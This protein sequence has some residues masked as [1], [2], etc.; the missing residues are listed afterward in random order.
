MKEFLRSYKVFLFLLLLI[1]Y[2]Y[3]GQAQQQT[4]DF[5]IQIL[6]KDS[7]NSVNQWGV[8]V[9]P[10]TGFADG[11]NGT[12]TASGQVTIL[13]NFSASDSITN[14]ESV[15][16]NWNPDYDLVRVPSVGG[17]CSG[18]TYS[19]G[20]P[21][22]K[23]YFFI[24]LDDE[25]AGV[26]L[27]DGIETLLF[28]FQTN[29]GCPDSLSLINNNTDPLNIPILNGDCNSLG[30]NPGMDL[31]VFNTNTGAIHNWQSNYA[32]QA[33]SC[34]DCDGDGIPD[35]LE[36][37]NGNEMFDVGVDS[38]DFCDPCDP[39]G[40]KNFSAMLDGGD[41]LS[42][43]SA[44]DSAGLTTTM[45]GG[46][47]PFTVYLGVTPN[48]GTKTAQSFPNINSG[49][50]FYV[51]PTITTDYQLDSIVD[52]LGCTL[53]DPDSLL[54]VVTVVVEG[55]IDWV[56]TGDTPEDVT[57]CT[58]DTIFF[59]VQADNSGDGDILYQWQEST[60]GGTT[61]TDIVNGTPYSLADTDSLLISNPDG[62]DGNLYRAKIFTETCDT[63]T[64]NAALLSVEGPFEI[65]ASPTDAAICGEDMVDFVAE[66]ANLGS[67]TIVRQWEVN[68]GSGWT[69]LADGGNYSGVTTDVLSIA[70]TAPGD[71]VSALNEHWYR[72]R[73]AGTNG[74]CTDIFTDSAQLIVEGP[75]TIDPLNLPKDTSSCA[76][77]VACFGVL[78][79]NPGAGDIDYQ[80]YMRQDAASSWVA[81]SNDGNF[82]GVRSDTLCVADAAGL[83]G[84]QFEVRFS[85]DECIEIAT[86]S[87]G[88][89]A[90]LS[91]TETIDFNID[92][93]SESICGSDVVQFIVD[94]NSLDPMLTKQ[95]QVSSDTGQTWADVAASA[96]YSG[97][98][99]DTLTVTTD[100]TATTQPDTLD[101]L[102]YRMS[103]GGQ[104]CDNVISREAELSVHVIDEANI[105]DPRDTTVCSGEAAYFEINVPYNRDEQE[106]RYRW[107]IL[108]P[109]GSVWTNLNPVGDYNGV[110]TNR[111]SISDV[112]G[113]NGMQFRA[114]VF[115]NECDTIFTNLATLT[116]EGPYVFGAN[117]DGHPQDTVVCA[118]EAVTFNA[119]PV[120]DMSTLDPFGVVNPGEN[121][122]L[123][124]V[125]VYNPLGEYNNP[126]SVSAAPWAA[127]AGISGAFTTT[128]DIAQVSGTGHNLDGYAF[129]LEVRSAEC[130][131]PA[132]SLP[133]I[134][135]IDG[136]LSVVLQPLDAAN[137]SDQGAV[138]AADI[139]NAGFGG[140]QTIEY[141]WREKDATTGVWRDIENDSIYNGA[142]SDTLSIDELF[143][144]NDNEYA[145][146]ATID[147]CSFIST[148]TVSLTEEG[149]I[150][151][152]ENPEDVITCSGQPGYFTATVI[153]STT[154]DDSRLTYN[155]QVSSDF[156][157]NWGNLTEGST[158]ADGGVYTLVETDSMYISDVT[159]L[160]GFRYRLAIT[161]LSGSCDT[162]FSTPARITAEGPIVFDPLS[163]ESIC[164]NEG[165]T[166]AA[167]IDLD[168]TKAGIP[169]L[170]WQV[171]DGSGWTNLTNDGNYDAVTTNQ[172]FIDRIMEINRTGVHTYDTLLNLDGYRYRIASTTKECR[173]VGTFFFSDSL[174]LN[175]VS[176]TTGT[177]DFDL[178]G[179][180]ND[181]DEDDDNDGLRDVIE[182][183]ITDG[184]EVVDSVNQFNSDT[185]FDGINDSEED[186]D[187]DTIN[188][189]EETDDDDGDG[190]PDE[191]E[192]D[193]DIFSGD[194]LDPCDPIL[195]PTCVGVVLD[196]KVKLQGAMVGQPRV[197]SQPMRDDLRE[198]DMIPLQEPYGSMK[199]KVLGTEQE[200]AFIH[201]PDHIGGDFVAGEEEIQSADKTAILGDQPNTDNNVIDW[202]FVELRSGIQLDSIIATRSALLQADG[203]VRDVVARQTPDATNKFLDSDGYT[204]LRFDSTLAGEYYVSV[205]H[206]NHL[207]VMTNEA[208]L[209]SPKL[210]IIDFIDKDMNALGTHPMNVF[211]TS[212]SRDD[213]GTITYADTLEQHMW[214]GDL[215]S[216]GKA[217]F[218][219][220]QN[221]VNEMFINVINLQPVVQGELPLDNFILSGYRRSD[222]NLD[223]NT[224]YQGPNND[225]Q[226]LIFNSILAFPDNQKL[227]ANYVI[228]E[229]LP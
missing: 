161:N 144:L 97:V 26:P 217:I 182:E 107:Q 45:S 66:T 31:A 181:V 83:D 6:E 204:Y 208:G 104:F 216:D 46:E 172:L 23:D 202:V 190:I 193:G 212:A 175:T 103:V 87:L 214:A 36:D 132:R 19:G 89:P 21:S 171:D 130:A 39:L 72:L 119:D 38:S 149:P 127:D 62:L 69:N 199:V 158:S 74:I 84:F 60:D 75:I 8:Y 106:L 82:S 54:G 53:T 51:K 203:D 68:D 164:S 49:D 177:C 24:G 198:K 173:A 156:G 20:S 191:S 81:I 93:L 151:V 162:V 96:I 34:E 58:L 138:F 10:S 170:Q 126:D 213:K 1:L 86:S 63:L 209:L 143:G 37:T 116:V 100:A 35:G 27:E 40:I 14:I 41:I 145:L 91:V 133:A 102:L 155:W 225:R 114:A 76:G 124:Y 184:G 201:V 140:E 25:G 42:V 94:I 229:Q 73:I 22:S 150:V 59:K 146:L 67:G 226:M 79:D 33:F 137:C 207:G 109:T 189:G 64:S 7:I 71:N 147:G 57:S 142:R 176:D 222:Y 174:T 9:R 101:G 78:V 50:T 157:R 52:A 92:P 188:N 123:T 105:T 223:G 220:G 196:V 153:D 148:D 12:V 70:P 125:W 186:A 11:A 121:S 160:N 99:R 128:L 200:A 90:T 88:A 219:G 166:F 2:A 224:I 65:N 44:Q 3:T 28:T 115:T 47:G 13:M 187:G 169:E 134:L 113:F 61:Y 117:D 29:T 180:I 179:Q 210:T 129:W 227:L 205:R 183:Y 118:G 195:S 5:K 185:D 215:N 165:A 48:G 221:D 56:G 154:L 211:A 18:G 112:N 111:L 80:W 163:D 122:T 30:N 135:R 98:D 192:E 194:P 85:T 108:N 206:R 110:T 228:L 167:I 218:Q 120:I 43:C 95:W 131:L 178:D 77:E 4:L 159:G 136:P 152:N 139:E 32:P 55:P 168:A 16:G 197:A 17:S 141:Q 15:N